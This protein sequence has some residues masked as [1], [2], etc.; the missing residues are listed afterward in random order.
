LL[1]ELRREVPDDSEWLFPADESHRKDVRDNWDRLC[2]AAKIKGARVHDLRHTYASILASS[3]H[4]LKIIGELLGHTQPST[5]D[6][7]AH[8]FDDPLRQAAER[9]GAIL[10]GKPSAEVVPIKGGR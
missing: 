4:G 6:R 7:Y 5:T 2:H 10:S 9:A 8:L 3:G 1:S